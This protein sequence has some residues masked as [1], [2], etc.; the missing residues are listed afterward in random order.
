[1][2]TGLSPKYIHNINETIVMWF[3]SSNKYIVVS[4]NVYTLVLLFLNVKGKAEFIDTLYETLQI[5]NEK[6]KE[7]FSEIS[8]FLEDANTLAIVDI[9]LNDKLEIPKTNIERSY[10]FDGK[11]IRIN[12]ETALIESLIHPQIEHHTVDKISDA[13]AE[14][15]IFKTSDSLHLFKNKSHIGSYNTKSFHFLQG[16]F[17][18]E[19][20]NSI[21]NTHIDNWVA[22]F[23]ASTVSHN[24]ESIMIIGDSGNGKS[25]LSALLMS[26]GL[27]VLADD[28]S[29]LYA[30]MHI[31]RYPA[32]ISIKKGAFGILEASMENFE[33]LK[34]HK[35]GPKKV[36]LKYLPPSTKFSTSASNF[37]CHKIVIVNFDSSK[38][39]QLKQIPVENILETLIPE[40]WISP[41]ETHSLKFLNWLEHLQCYELCYSDNDFAISKFKALFEV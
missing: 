27:D 11:I 40:S 9:T 1:M 39:S 30:D 6:C 4:A 23:H 35:N 22:T 20:T 37:P 41:N 7:I 38:P 32:A 33:T 12:F 14:F 31:Y 2:K 19:L 29:P 8:N 21:H 36:N 28:F 18:L 26:N 3:Q 10:D 15:D 5:E 13:I 25:T 17:A 24:S 16:K 34:I